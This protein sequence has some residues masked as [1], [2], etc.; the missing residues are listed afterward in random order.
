MD[1]LFMHVSEGLNGHKEEFWKKLL[2]TKKVHL[3][4]CICLKILS[5]QK[6]NEN[7]NKN[8]EKH[9]LN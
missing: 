9:L 7:K 3:D 8:L 6:Q 2:T 1:F 4:I 5:V